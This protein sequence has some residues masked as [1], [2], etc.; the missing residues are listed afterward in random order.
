MLSF[1]RLLQGVCPWIDGALLIALCTQSH[2]VVLDVG[3]L[4]I[5]TM[6]FIYFGET[7]DEKP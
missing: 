3:K 4:G 5:E 2:E 1:V 6:G 7:M